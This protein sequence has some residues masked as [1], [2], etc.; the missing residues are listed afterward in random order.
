MKN[1]GKGWEQWKSQSVAA[2]QALVC[3][4]EQHSLISSGHK[5]KQLQND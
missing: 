5:M 3:E 2:V 1:G 4:E